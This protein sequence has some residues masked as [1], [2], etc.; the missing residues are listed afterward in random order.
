ME[1]LVQTGNG[2]TNRKWQ[3][4]LEMLVRTGNVNIYSKWQ[5]LQGLQMYDQYYNT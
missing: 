5:G 2:H 1:M 4:K 3:Y